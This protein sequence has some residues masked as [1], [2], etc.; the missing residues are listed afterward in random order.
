MTLFIILEVT[1]LAVAHVV[2]GP[3]WAAV[4]AVACVAH[5]RAGLQPAALVAA[6][7]ALGWLVASRVSGNRELFFPYSM[8]LA[9]S[10]LLAARVRQPTADAAA[11]ASVVAAFLT[12]R[13]VQ[14]APGRVLAIECAAAVAVLAAAV[15]ARA[16]GPSVAV[17]WWLPAAAS[18]AAFAC[19][20]L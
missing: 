12:A 20:A 8:L 1:I 15:A 13:V 3:A 4:A 9:I 7:P 17:G 6:L 2:G 10:A 18:L 11:A 19:L 16:W 5:L 14:R